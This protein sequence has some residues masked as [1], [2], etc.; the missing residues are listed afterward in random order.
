MANDHKSTPP[1]VTAAMDQSLSRARENLA[2]LITQYKLRRPDMDQAHALG[3]VLHELHSQCEK[4]TRVHEQL[5][6]I[7][8]LGSAVVQLSEL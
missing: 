8:M 1:Y 6:L 2:Q 4:L 3:G 5:L 7:E